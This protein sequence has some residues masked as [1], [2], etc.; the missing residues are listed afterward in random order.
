L[1]GLATR[2]EAVAGIEINLLK[3]NF[4]HTFAA[5]LKSAGLFLL[6]NSHV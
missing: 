1:A 3:I 6:K 2:A 5:L 4:L